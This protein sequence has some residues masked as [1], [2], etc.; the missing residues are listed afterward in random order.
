MFFTCVVSFISQADVKEMED[1]SSIGVPL[2][3]VAG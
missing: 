3:G 2:E 1:L